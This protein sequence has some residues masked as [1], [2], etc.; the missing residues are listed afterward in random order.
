MAPPQRQSDEGI[1]SKV[2]RLVDLLERALKEGQ[3]VAGDRFLST[4]KIAEKYGVSQGTARK[5]MSELAGRG[6]LEASARSGYFVR[7]VSVVKTAAVTVS[8]DP[9]LLVLVGEGVRGGGNI[10]NDYV[11]SLRQASEQKGWQVVRVNNHADEIAAAVE[12]RHVV[13]CLAYGLCTPPVVAIDLTSTII[14]NRTSDWRDSDCSQMGLDTD[15]AARLAYGHLW[16]LGHEHTAMVRLPESHEAIISTTTG[17]VLGMRKAYAAMGY[18]W[19]ADDVISAGPHVLPTLYKRLRDSGITGIVCGDWT[20][21]QELYRQ[22]SE[23]GERVGER[24]SLVYIGGHDK[25]Q[26][27]HPTPAR[28]CWRAVDYAAVVVDAIALRAQG[29][30][31]PRHLTVPVHLEEGPGAGYLCDADARAATSSQAILNR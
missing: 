18:R 22:A 9:V 13:G 10:L 28:I 24:L 20:V 4:Y 17:L 8:S 2:G 3:F 7:G 29:R 12:G 6:Y 19:T 25:F 14:W 15:S 23:Q 26:T 31:M 21:L 11:A 1:G 5:A 27:V 30:P 16:D